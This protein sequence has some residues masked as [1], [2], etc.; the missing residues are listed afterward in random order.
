MLMNTIFTVYN[1]IIT[2]LET[3]LY[4]DVKASLNINIYTELYVKTIFYRETSNIYIY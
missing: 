3:D 1:M 4:F 2:L